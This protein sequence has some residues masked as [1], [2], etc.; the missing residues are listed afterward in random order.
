MERRIEFPPPRQVAAPDGRQ[1][2]SRRLCKT[3]VPATL[4]Y[5]PA[6]QAVRQLPWH[7]DGDEIQGTPPSHLGTVGGVE[8]FGQ[9]I[10]LPSTR[11]SSCPLFHREM[12]FENDLLRMCHTVFPGIKKVASGLNKGEMGIIEQRPKT[13]AQKIGRRNIVGIKNRNKRLAG[14][15]E[16]GP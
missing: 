10:G 11:P 4:L 9:C 15:S 13:K 12:A 1:K 16:P 2:P 7:G 5:P 6:G 3:F 14:A 8:I